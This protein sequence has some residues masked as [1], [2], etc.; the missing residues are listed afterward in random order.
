[1]VAWY[2]VVVALIAGGVM[3]FGLF[4]LLTISKRA[5]E[6]SIADLIDNEYEKSTYEDKENDR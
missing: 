3:G 6:V 5:D 2:W 4:A 1:M